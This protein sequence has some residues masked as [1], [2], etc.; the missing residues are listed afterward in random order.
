MQTLKFKH[1][2][3]GAMVQAISSWLLT[4]KVWFRNER[5]HCRIFSGKI[6]HYDMFFS[7][8][9]DLALLVSLQDCSAVE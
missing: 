3:G 6:C 8:C 9:L 1:R 5:S 4:T 7:K 2:G